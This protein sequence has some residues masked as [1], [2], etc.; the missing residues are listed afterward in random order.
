MI[1]PE[2]AQNSSQG[3]ER[4]VIKRSRRGFSAL[5]SMPCPSETTKPGWLEVAEN[6]SL[7]RQEVPNPQQPT[8]IPG[9]ASDHSLTKTA[10]KIAINVV[11]LLKNLI[12]SI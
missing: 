12:H 1:S 8:E 4:S 6:P 5:T 9:K 3:T 2:N 7:C 11:S 10:F